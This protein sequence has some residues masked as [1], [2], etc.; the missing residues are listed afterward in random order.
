MFG[1][2]AEKINKKFYK[3][4]EEITFK[5]YSENKEPEVLPEPEPAVVEAPPAPQPKAEPNVK[6]K[7]IH[8]ETFEEVSKIADHLLDGCT[9]LLNV[10]GLDPAT[11]GRMLDFLNGVTYTIDG[12]INPVSK[13]T[14][15][16]AP[17]DVDVSA[18]EEA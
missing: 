12:V 14:F 15:V 5:D 9:V 17:S 16:I 6:F 4:E 2:L 7:V 11:T 1:N 13:D 10:E 8:P 18:D 3:E